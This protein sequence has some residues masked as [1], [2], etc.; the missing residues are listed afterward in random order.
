MIMEKK[1]RAR[2]Y[3]K[4]VRTSLLGSKDKKIEEACQFGQLLFTTK[5]YDFFYFCYVVF[6][7]HIRAL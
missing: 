6:Y 3:P 7:I 2:S 1:K 5:C 4:V